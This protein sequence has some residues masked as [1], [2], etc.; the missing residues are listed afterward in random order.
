MIIDYAFKQMP[1]SDGLREYASEKS[2]KLKKFFDGK[3][4]VKW[5]FT[6]EHEEFIAHCH[7]I[8]NHMDFFGEATTSDARTSIDEAL[9][10]VE[11]QIKK[12]KEILTGHHHS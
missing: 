6:R 8:G 2:E 11:K 12:H 9:S 10:K 5:N 3:M 7:L 4:H 1:T